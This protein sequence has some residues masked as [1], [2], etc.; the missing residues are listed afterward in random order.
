MT[1]DTNQAEA[2]QYSCADM[3]HAI[4]DVPRVNGFS[5]QAI[6]VQITF[7]PEQLHVLQSSLKEAPSL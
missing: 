2:K 7:P 1:G 4:L 3:L 6:S 5:G